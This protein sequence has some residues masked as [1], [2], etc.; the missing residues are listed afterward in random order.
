[1]YSDVPILDSGIVISERNTDNDMRALLEQINKNGFDIYANKIY[2]MYDSKGYNNMSI[3]EI[4]TV[5]KLAGY[6]YLSI[7]KIDEHTRG[8]IILSYSPP[9][10]N[11]QTQKLTSSD[12]PDFRLVTPVNGYTNE[13]E[14]APGK[15]FGCGYPCY[16]NKKLDI[17]GDKEYM[18]GSVSYPSI[19]TPP[20]YAVYKINAS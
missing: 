5:G 7:Y 9:L 1:M 18:C 6:N 16:K 13:E 4:A 3:L 10:D 19:K 12:L 2:N 14:K 20:R 11:I 8:K 17:N 15:V